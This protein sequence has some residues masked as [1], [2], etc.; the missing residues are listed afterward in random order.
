MLKDVNDFKIGLFADSTVGLR[1]TEFMIKN[2]IADLGFICVTKQDSPIIQKSIDWG[3]D[4]SQIYV[5]DDIKIK[6]D[7]NKFD[8][9]IL[10]WWP[11]IVDASLFNIPK[12]GTLNFHPSLLPFNR[13]KHPTFWNIIEDVPYGVT[14]HFIDEGIDTGDIVFQKDI[15]K[16]WEDTG[17]SLYKKAIIGIV[18]LFIEN[19]EAI[20]NGSY[21]KIKQPDG[22]SFHYAC[23]SKNAIN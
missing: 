9:F 11:Y 10:S 14:I 5:Y 22:G 19:Y 4:P 6:W 20:K 7:Q 17:E 16:S 18:R 23:K 21:K 2:H 8:Y 1:T 3:F 12:I 15:K 13:G